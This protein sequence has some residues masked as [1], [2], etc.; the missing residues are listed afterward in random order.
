[1]PCIHILHEPFRA[2]PYM[3]AENLLKMRRFVTR[4]LREK[5]EVR[6]L[7]VVRG[8]VID[9]IGYNGFFTHTLYM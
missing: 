7:R 9:C 4:P 3:L 1:M 8:Q 5:I 6:L 2:N